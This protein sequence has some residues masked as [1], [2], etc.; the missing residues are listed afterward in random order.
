MK[1]THLEMLPLTGKKSRYPHNTRLGLYCQRDESKVVQL[2]MFVKWNKVTLNCK[3][4][5]KNL[6]QKHCWI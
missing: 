3:E 6:L 4:T 5:G 2:Q 1:K